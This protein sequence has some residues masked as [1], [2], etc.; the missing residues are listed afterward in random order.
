MTSLNT[1]K[2]LTKEDGTVSFASDTGWSTTSVSLSNVYLPS[3]T[4]IFVGTRDYAGGDRRYSIDSGLAGINTNANGNI[5]G[6]DIGYHEQE[7]FTITV[8]WRVVGV[9]R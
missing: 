1:T 9:T 8:Y 4:S 2:T 7:S 6:I 5:T 3:Q